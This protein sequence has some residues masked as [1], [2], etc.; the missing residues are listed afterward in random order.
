MFYL[1]KKQFNNH[2]K[3]ISVSN[4]SKNE[5]RYY[6]GI[7]KDNIVIIPNGVDIEKFNPSNK[8]NEIRERYG[9][10]IILYSGLMVYRKRITFQGTY[11]KIKQC[12][13]CRHYC[14]Q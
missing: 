3:I 8:S 6:Y 4:T 11:I 1:E 2:K 12:V 5:I 14:L 10:N 7:K 13:V 9:N